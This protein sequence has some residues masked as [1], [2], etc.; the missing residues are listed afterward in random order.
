MIT[1]IQLIAKNEKHALPII[2]SKLIAKEEKAAK[3]IYL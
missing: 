1:I 3:C 2:T